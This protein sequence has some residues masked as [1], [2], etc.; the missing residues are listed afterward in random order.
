MAPKKAQAR[1][2]ELKKKEKSL[3]NTYRQHHTNQAKADH[4]EEMA[5]VIREIDT[6][7]N[8]K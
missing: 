2:K 5:A 6:L 4:L 1:L 3:F 8:G 7:E